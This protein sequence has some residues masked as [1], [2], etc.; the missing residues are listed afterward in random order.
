[1]LFYTV[2]LGLLLGGNK[3][4][5]LFISSCSWFLQGGNNLSPKSSSSWAEDEESVV[6][7]LK[8]KGSTFAFFGCGCFGGFICCFVLSSIKSANCLEVTPLPR[9]SLLSFNFLFN[10]FCCFLS[11]AFS[12]SF[13]FLQW[14]RQRILLAVS[15]MHWMLTCG[16]T[17]VWDVLWWI[18]VTDKQSSVRGRPATFTTVSVLFFFSMATTASAPLVPIPFYNGMGK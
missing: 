9:H 8:K 11:F 16:N 3:S 6:R 2:T 17:V 13:S 7:S 18:L 10:I 15:S 1:M 14:S 5:S 4:S 12:L